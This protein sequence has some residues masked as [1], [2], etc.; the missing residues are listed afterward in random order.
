MEEDAPQKTIIALL[1]LTIIISVLGTWY[2]LDSLNKVVVEEKASSGD[3]SEP[4]YEE[5]RDSSGGTVSLTIKESGI[6]E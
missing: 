3:F 5:R 2:V 1:V 4:A 6:N